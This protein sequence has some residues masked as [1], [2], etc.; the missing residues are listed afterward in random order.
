MNSDLNLFQKSKIV[1]RYPIFNIVRLFLI[2]LGSL[3]LLLL[4][5]AF[6]S[7]PFWIWYGLGT[8]KAGISTYPGFIV[9]LGG[10]G[11][12]SETGLMRTWY[13]AKAAEYFPEAKVIVAL[14]GD[15]SDSLSSIN[16]MRDELLL[17]GVSPGRIMLEDSGTNTRAQALKIK[18]MIA[19]YE[20]R[21]CAIPDS[22]K[23]ITNNRLSILDSQLSILLVTSPE[24]LYRAV[25]TFRRAGFETVDGLPA[26][27]SD[28]ESDITFSARKLGG[29]RWVPDVGDSITLRYQFWT[30]LL[31]EILIL[32]EWM[33]ITYYWVMGW[34]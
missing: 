3:C 8:S 13:A 34:I 14:P 17:R 28:I 5:L 16:K 6:T 23:P 19:D 24:H 1:N 22:A 10:S 27:A 15:T 9:V 11:I 31:Y 25:L 33:A 12:P 29:R 2:F 32:R 18:D 7:A 4:I 20:L 21:T 30:Q 26:F